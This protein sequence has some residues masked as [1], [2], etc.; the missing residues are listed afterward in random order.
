[1][2]ELTD[3]LNSWLEKQ[4]YHYALGEW[5]KGKST[6][7]ISTDNLIDKL[8]AQIKESYPIKDIRE[9]LTTIGEDS[10]A[11]ESDAGDASTIN[12]D[13]IAQIGVSHSLFSVGDKTV[14][15]E[16]RGYAN[17][18]NAND[19]RLIENVVYAKDNEE[20]IIYFIKTR[21]ESNCSQ[22][23]L[24]PGKKDDLDIEG[25]LLTCGKYTLLCN[26]FESQLLDWEREIV[27]IWNRNVRSPYEEVQN[28]ILANVPVTLIANKTISIICTERETG[29]VANG[30][31]LTIQVAHGVKWE[32]KGARLRYSDFVA[33]NIDTFRTSSM[34]QLPTM[35]KIYGN[36]GQDAMSIFDISSYYTAPKDYVLSEEWQEVKSK[37][38]EDEWAVLCAWTMGMLDAKNSGR[39]ALAQIDYDGYSGKS[40]YSDVLIRFLGL[41][42]CCAIGKGSLSTQFWASK[43]WNK[44]LVV[45]DDNKNP[46]LNQTEA[47]HC[48]LGGGY[49]DVEYKGESSFTWKMSSK[50][51]VN[52]NVDLDVNSSMLHERSRV[53][54]IKPKMPKSLITKLSAKDEQGNVILDQN[55]NPKLLGDPNFADKLLATI[56]G[57]LREA[58]NYYKKLCPNRAD[59]VV[60]NSVLEHTYSSEAVEET[61][62]TGI[63]NKAFVV[64]NDNSDTMTQSEFMDRYMEVTKN[65]KIYNGYASSQEYSNFKL[66]IKKVCKIEAGGKGRLF[67]GIKVSS[68]VPL[69]PATST[70]YR[71]NE[72]RPVQT[73]KGLGGLYHTQESVLEA[74]KG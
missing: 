3:T 16:L 17:V 31:E 23:T 58:M 30:E 14:S 11:E 4:K 28:Y 63:L 72:V 68:Y 61:V 29:V 20:R 56:D 54:I 6:T 15:I 47:M 7:G 60:P 19:A 34:V 45:S 13:E 49:S 39:Q 51:L 67:K 48:V 38:T 71:R 57:F 69:D 37:Y 66:Y 73:A 59:I 8:P 52:S 41:N 9:S 33:L 40:V 1:M 25:A 26:W 5:Y 65:T 55:G 50:V 44:R 24:I 74:L 2:S 10:S 22:Y 64:S 42:N 46:K 21:H 27:A 18:P 70:S 32:Y 35:P 12:Y 36:A 62:F 53:I 43:M